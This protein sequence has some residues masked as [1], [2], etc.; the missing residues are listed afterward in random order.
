MKCP[1]CGEE[2]QSGK[3]IGDG[4][5]SLLWRTGDKKRDFFDWLSGKD[6]FVPENVE[7]TLTK[8]KIISDYCPKCEKLIID[9]KMSKY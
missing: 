4:R 6:T 2:M 3:L 9:T 7:R 8:F 1:F 5:D